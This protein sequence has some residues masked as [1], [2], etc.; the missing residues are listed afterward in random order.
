[1]SMSVNFYMPNTSYV[2]TFKIDATFGGS[3]FCSLRV[4]D[5]QHNEVTIMIEKTSE[6]LLFLDQ[7]RHSVDL[8]IKWARSE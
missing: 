7:L 8:A 3:E 4:L 1:M 5:K 2:D 6:S